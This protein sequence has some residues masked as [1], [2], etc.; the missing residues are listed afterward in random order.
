MKLATIGSGMIVE[1]FLDALSQVEGMQCEAIYS[2]TQVKA[3]ALADKFGVKKTYTSLTAMF[4]DP[5]IDVIYVASPNSLHFEQAKQALLAD[6][7]VICEKPLTSTLAELDALLELAHQQDKIFV[8]AITNIHLPNFNTL[9][10]NLAKIGEVKMVLCNF[11]QY[12]S[13][14]DLYK[15]GEVTNVFN[16]EFSG[17]ALMDLNVYNLHFVIGL[18]GKPS[19]ATY[20]P[21]LG[22]N[23]IDLAGVAI[24]EYPSMSAVCVAGKNVQ[25]Q[26]ASMIYG[27][28]GSIK[29]EGEVSLIKE[30][31]IDDGK[32]EQTYNNQ[33]LK[34]HMVYEIQAF[35]DII[36][37]HDTRRADALN[38]HSR[39]VYEVLH[40]I[41][42]DANIIFHA[43]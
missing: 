21:Q 31:V 2:R 23:G 28:Q 6:K 39:D 19:K 38:Q 15:K 20:H 7:H 25:A 27:E 8:E 43:D 30:F 9:K 14:M 22:F 10:E 12:S 11:L 24:L 33:N 29:I 32:S 42:R 18:F 3:Q 36:N 5:K 37:N 34:N 1:L 13:R 17:G 16:P 35:A 41:R 4:D 26:N 40:K